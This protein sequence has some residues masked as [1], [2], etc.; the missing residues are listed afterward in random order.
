[1][2]LVEKPQRL[3]KKVN[4][5]NECAN[6]TGP[7]LQEYMRVPPRCTRI[8]AIVE[9]TEAKYLKGIYPK[10]ERAL[11]FKPRKFHER[12]VLEGTLPKFV[13]KCSCKSLPLNL[14]KQCCARITSRIHMPRIVSSGGRQWGALDEHQ[15]QTGAMQI[16]TCQ[17]E[18]KAPGN[19]TK[20]CSSVGAVPVI[21]PMRGCKLGN[22]NNN[23]KRKRNKKGKKKR[24]G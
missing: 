4:V 16:A 11:V 18:F 8:D 7:K 1:M 3:K 13:K 19:K 14:R 17:F 21:A 6:R 12:S 2:Q 20:K 15:H 10:S 9:N 22:S 23:E 5:Q 24:R